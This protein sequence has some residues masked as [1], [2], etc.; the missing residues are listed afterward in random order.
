[1]QDFEQQRLKIGTAEK[2]K[3]DVNSEKERRNVVAG[4]I[5]NHHPG[6]DMDMDWLWT[7]RSVRSFQSQLVPEPVITML[8]AAAVQ[9]PSAH[10]RQPWRFVV[11]RSVESRSRLAEAMA[12]KFFQD[13][14]SDSIP[15]DAA[16]PR[17]ESAMRRVI[18]APVCIVVCLDRSLEDHYPEQRRQEAEFLKGVQ[19]VAMAGENMLLAAHQLGLGGCWMCAPLFAPEEAS[20]ALDLPPAW[21]P[22]G[23]VLLG[24][25]DSVPPAKERL[26]A[27]QVTVYR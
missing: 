2:S 9:A 23:M 15:L 26:T 19:G 27:S 10:N 5:L 24:Y 1:M 6:L 20:Q 25:P 22:M 21:R 14:L 13:M 16:I 11:C 3:E 17:R 18:D 7:R 4:N 8:L 12:Q